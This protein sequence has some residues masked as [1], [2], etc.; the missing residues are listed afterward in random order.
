MRTNG[1][2]DHEARLVRLEGL[3][4]KLAMLAQAYH[5]L[6]QAVGEIAAQIVLLDKRRREDAQEIHEALDR[7][8]RRVQENRERIN[9]MDST[10][11]ALEDITGVRH[12]PALHAA[13]DARLAAR[14][15]AKAQAE[16]AQVSEARRHWTRWAAATLGALAVAL[17]SAALGWYLRR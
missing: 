4:P 10:R 1:Q 9:V 2:D 14:D 5:D 16:L 7:L 8:R 11:E 17:A 15:L 13:L 6:S 3:A 12:A